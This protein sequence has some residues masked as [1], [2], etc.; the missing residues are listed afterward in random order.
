[1]KVWG[2]LQ[3]LVLNTGHASNEFAVPSKSIDEIDTEKVFSNTKTIS[4]EGV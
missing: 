4:I 1:M 3:L 2:R